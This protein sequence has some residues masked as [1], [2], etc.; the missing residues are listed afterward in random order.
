MMRE[1]N[2]YLR[3]CCDYREETGEKADALTL[4]VYIRVISEALI[5]F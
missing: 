3:G 1:G 5:K 4:V 2:I